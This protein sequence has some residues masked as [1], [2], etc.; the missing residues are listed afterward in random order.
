[1]GRFVIRRIARKPRIGNSAEIHGIYRKEIRSTTVGD[2]PMHQTVSA[3]IRR[4]VGQAAWRRDDLGGFLC[5]IVQRDH[6]GRDK[7]IRKLFLLPHE[8]EGHIAELDK[9]RSA[10][11]AQPGIVRIIRDPFDCSAAEIFTCHRHKDIPLLI[12]IILIRTKI[13]CDQ[14]AGC[15]QLN[16][17][18]EALV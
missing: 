18:I 1:M 8:Q 4:A 15:G 6:F 16:P 9:M 3:E 7:T 17:P 10:G 14:A 2:I 5:I 11:F 12:H 13:A